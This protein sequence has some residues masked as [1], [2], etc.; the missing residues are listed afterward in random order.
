MESHQ[1]PGWYPDPSGEDDQYRYFDGSNWSTET[2]DDPRHPPPSGA[3]RS[4]T[5]RPVAGMI[6][7]ALALAVM[8]IIVGSVIVGNLRSTT[9]ESLPAPSVLESTGNPDDPTPTESLTPPPVQNPRCASGNPDKRVTHPDDGRVYGGNLSFPAQSNFEPA[10]NESRME[11]GWDV[12]Q[13]VRS[14]STKPGWVAQFAVGQLRRS[15]GFSADPRRAAD[16]TLACLLGGSLYQPYAG[17]DG[18]RDWML[19][20]VDGKKAMAIL[21]NVLVDVPELD[22]PGDLTLVVVVPDEKN[23]GYF[24]GAVPLGNKTLEEQLRATVA[25]LRIT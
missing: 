6:I 10:A 21:A 17:A 4:G 1:Q 5:R 25:S 9:D 22:F 15:D 8:L 2:A 18:S 24:F 7:G 14:V 16:Q 23:Y 19:L 11:F 3:T 20:Q 12:T 13:Q